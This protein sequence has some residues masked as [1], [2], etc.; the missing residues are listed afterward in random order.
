MDPKYK[1]TVSIGLIIIIAGV[2]SGW[3][4]YDGYY[5]SKRIILATT[6]STYDSGL[7]DYLIPIFEDRYNIPVHVVSVGTGA[8]LEMGK[9]GNADVIL[10]HA[11]TREDAF[12]NE[13]HGVHRVCVMY[14]D[15]VLVGPSDDSA[16]IE[17]E[18]ITS[19]MFNLISAGNLADI[20]FYS[21]GDS[22]GT[23]SKEL[24]LWN[25]TDFIPN[26]EEDLWYK[27]TGTGMG[28]TLTIAN[29]ENGYTLVDRGT[30]ISMKDNLNLVILSEGDEN[31]LN[32]YGAILVNPELH[33]GVKFDL[34]VKFIGFL[35][36][37]LGQQLIGDYRKNGELLFHPAFGI[38]N[39]IH[40][41]ITTTDEIT[42]WSQFNGGFTG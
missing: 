21:R 8:A 31:L 42:Y 34:A 6:T 23:H 9:A 28:T 25:L 30:W 1:K 41:C 36:S 4:I 14:N 37:E 13:G 12:I 40:S 29:E 3:A 19:V 24:G 20:S 22:S 35:V 16:E 10:V 17:G 15:F 39:S 18:N 33:S 32:P 27:E 26:S 7:L 5:S 11:R 2:F 38:N